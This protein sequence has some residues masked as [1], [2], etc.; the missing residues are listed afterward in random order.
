VADASAIMESAR[1]FHVTLDRFVVEVDAAG[2]GAALATKT[3]TSA[4]TDFTVKPLVLS[5][6]VTLSEQSE[7]AALKITGYMGATQYYHGQAAVTLTNGATEQPGA[8]APVYDGPGADADSI[9]FA[10][11][12]TIQATD[13]AV[14]SAT[15]L[16]AGVVIP[17]VPVQFTSA[18]SDKIL[19][20]RGASQSVNQGWAIGLGITLGTTSV[21]ARLPNQPGS[22]A[23]SSITVVSPAASVARVSGDGQT[24]LPSAT[25]SP[26]VV[27]VRNG[28]GQGFGGT[29]AVHFTINGPAG[30]ALTV[31]DAVTDDSGHAQTAVHAGA[32]AGAVSV[33]AFVT[34]HVAPISGSPVAFTS[35]ISSGTP[36]H[37]VALSP[38]SQT[39][40]VNSLVIPPSVRVTDSAGR[41]LFGIPVTFHVTS[42]CGLLNS[43]QQVVQVTTDTAGVASATSWRVGT[44]A[45]EPD[46]V[47]ASLVNPAL[48][49]EFRAQSRPAAPGIVYTSLV[50]QVRPVN[51]QLP[52]PLQLQVMDSFSNPISNLVI[53]WSTP[54]GGTFSPSN[55]R[56]DT[57]GVAA[58]LWTLGPSAGTQHGS[59]TIGNLPLQHFD[60]L[61]TS[62]S[63]V[64]TLTFARTPGVG[65]GLE[66]VIHASLSVPVPSNS[67]LVYPSVDPP[68]G[69]V[70][71]VGAPPLSQGDTSVDF[72]VFGITI[73]STTL[74]LNA[75]GYAD[76]TLPLTVEN[77]TAVI[78]DSV[79]LALGQSTTVPIHIPNPA[80]PGGATFSLE[81][82]DSLIVSASSP[83]LT[84]PAGS[85]DGS[86]TLTRSAPGVA[87]I[88]VGSTSYVGGTIT[89][90]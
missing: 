4:Q 68:F 76:A 54:D 82:S 44:N 31:T 85:Q 63:A 20:R 13:T 9:H 35:T 37:L 72:S 80:P 61:A 49:L 7:P 22:H 56:T 78:P 69:I 47:E 6:A 50:F 40:V 73:G 64:V 17:G 36:A 57:A 34:R 71:V 43:N 29:A 32:T 45:R 28:A 41:H 77:R 51:T 38:D 58:A 53:T 84:I 10:I 48:T 23:S 12:T 42:C 66:T 55:S 3:F 87:F 11:D 67:F 75:P 81:S 21:T 33:H 39:A 14:I 15:A 46:L 5:L 90:P 19:V 24:L 8:P 79:I 27:V 30:A 16:K 2:G 26:M 70:Q 52:R 59:A 89:L 18:D 88:F 62:G 65:L 74:H 86:V 60:A 1:I 25:S 83:T